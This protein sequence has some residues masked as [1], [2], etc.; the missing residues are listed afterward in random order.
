MIFV[1]SMEFSP[2]G[3]AILSVSA[4][5]SA[6]ITTVATGRGGRGGLFYLL[7]LLFLVFTILAIYCTNIPFDSVL[8]GILPRSTSNL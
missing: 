8:S 5:S 4:D 6:R 1:T 2:R 3:G 7:A